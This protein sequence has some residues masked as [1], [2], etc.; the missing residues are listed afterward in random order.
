MVKKRQSTRLSGA[1]TK[2]SSSRETL[3]ADAVQS[4]PVSPVPQRL[5]ISTGRDSQGTAKEGKVGEE[6]KPVMKLKLNLASIP[7]NYVN[8]IQV[9]SLT[10]TSPIPS[11]PVRERTPEPKARTEEAPSCIHPSRNARQA[12]GGQTDQGGGTGSFTGQ[13]KG[14]GTGGSGDEASH[15]SEEARTTPPPPPVTAPQ[16]RPI[17]AVSPT[18]P[19]P[20]RKKRQEHSYHPEK[21]K[22]HKKTLEERAAI[23]AKRQEESLQGITRRRRGRPTKEEARLRAQE[24]EQKQRTQL[25]SAAMQDLVDHA[26]DAEIAA[27]KDGVTYGTSP[28]DHLLPSIFLF[29]EPTPEHISQGNGVGAEFGALVERFNRIATVQDSRMGQFEL[30][31]LDQRLCLEEEKFLL[32][33]LQQLARSQA[34]RSGLSS[35]LGLLVHDID[36]TYS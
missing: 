4:A 31:I 27:M 21:R 6:A 8:S 30:A 35:T 13:G 5:R 20:K 14:G 32:S 10:A 34:I 11:S 18:E 3:D 9:S 2:N 26:W 7:T 16:S 23:V 12:K 24:R 29:W 22:Y 25:T 33:K 15:K 28:L 17:A 36:D 1:S 19:R